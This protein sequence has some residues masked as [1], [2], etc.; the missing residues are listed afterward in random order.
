MIRKILHYLDLN[1][2][3]LRR[4]RLVQIILLSTLIFLLLLLFVL[5]YNEF[6]NESKLKSI[7]QDL[8]TSTLLLKQKEIIKDDYINIYKNLQE[9]L[10]SKDASH[11]KNYYQSLEVLNNHINTFLGTISQNK[12]LVPF[13]NQEKINLSRIRDEK[14]LLDS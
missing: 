5:I 9:F 14:R 13:L 1:L 11:L 4:T 6:I 2:N 12:S 3:V 10:I 7:K 8:G